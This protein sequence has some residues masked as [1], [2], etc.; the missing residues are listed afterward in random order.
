MLIQL[1]V[2]VNNVIYQSRCSWAVDKTWDVDICL[3]L[4]IVRNTACETGVS[5]VLLGLARWLALSG[6][7]ARHSRSVLELVQGL[8]TSIEPTNASQIVSVCE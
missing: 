1:R 6:M 3:A 7:K 5:Q 4:L 2:L 8:F